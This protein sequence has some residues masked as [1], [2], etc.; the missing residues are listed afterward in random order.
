M[1]W[2]LTKSP[3][4]SCWKGFPSGATKTFHFSLRLKELSP[5]PLSCPIFHH[6]CSA[7]PFWGSCLLPFSRSGSSLNS[8]SV[9]AVGRG[10]KHSSLLIFSP[11]PPAVLPSLPSKSPV[12]SCPV[13]RG[14][15][16]LWMARPVPRVGGRDNRSTSAPLGCF[17]RLPPAQG[18]SPRTCPDTLAKAEQRGLDAARRESPDALSERLKNVITASEMVLLLWEVPLTPPVTMQWMGSSNVHT[19]V[20]LHTLFAFLQ[21]TKPGRTGKKEKL[22]FTSPVDLIMVLSTLWLCYRSC[23]FG[24]IQDMLHHADIWHMGLANRLS[25]AK[26]T[27]T[28]T[29]ISVSCDFLSL[30]GSCRNVVSIFRPRSPTM[31]AKTKEKGHCQRKSDLSETLTYREYCR[32]WI[33]L[34]LNTPEVSH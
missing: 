30:V 34:L 12:W 33:V 25:K 21:S 5:V 17:T 10:K 32:C 16:L 14:E 4:H 24:Y 29:L 31:K 8:L 27:Y 11:S 26:A 13:C 15:E 9:L 20:A 7:H 22:R 6:L 3:T 18:M 1:A 23:K 19:L 2:K 28:A